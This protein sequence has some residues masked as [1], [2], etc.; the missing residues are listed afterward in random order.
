MIGL[1]L[2]IKKRLSKPAFLVAIALIIYFSLGLSTISTFITADEHFWLPNYGTERIQDYWRAIAKRD[3]VDTRINDKPGITLAYLSGLAIPFTQEA[4][5]KQITFTDGVIKIFDPAVTE[6]LSFAFRLPVFLFNGL[7]VAGYLFW[8]LKK[9]TRDEWVSAWTTSLMLLSPVL[10]GI[11]QIV[12]PDTLFWTFGS[13]TIFTFFAFLELRE[14]RFVWLTTLFFGLT[15]A[16]KYVGVILFPFF[17]IMILLHYLFRFEEHSKANQSFPER[18]KRDFSAYFTIIIGATVI[19]S[20]LMPAVFVKPKF[21]YESTIG[22]KGMPP[23]FL[24]LLAGILL[25]LW[26]AFRWQSKVLMNILKHLAPHTR[27]L[28]R[29][30]TSVLLATVVFALFNWLLRNSLYDLSDIPFDA[31]TKSSFT[32]DNPLLARWIVEFVPL[33][34]ALT[35][36]TLF[37][38]IYFWTHSLFASVK[39]RLLTFTLSLFFLIFY[40]AVIKQGLLVTIRYSIILFPFALLLGSFGIKAFFRSTDPKKTVALK[41]FASIMG[42]FVVSYTLTSFHQ[43]LPSLEGRK[44]ERYINAHLLWFQTFFITL[45]VILALLFNRLFRVRAIT[46]TRSATLSLAL[47]AVSLVSL[48]LIR[49]HYFIY[50]S[51]LLPKKYLLTGS[52]SYGGYEAAQYLNAKPNAKDL[53]LW[54]DAHG[55]CEFFVG[56]CI[57][58]TKLDVEQ[59]P[60]DYMFRSFSGQL[61]PKFPFNRERKPEWEY[62]LD[63]RPKNFI[64]LYKNNY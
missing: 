35:P 38:L 7:F 26:D 34:F 57:R 55:V 14:K 39:E 62:T 5:A 8:I 17:V 53:T 21:L 22:F 44:F 45:S 30:V 50:T 20:L 32:T 10:L 19:L 36:I 23:I 40:A 2:C 13:A 6:K 1:F 49:P 29:V 64:R 42:V 24:T 51:D 56:K 52:W 61:S 25:L 31:K 47:V 41:A 59:Y 43:T 63:G 28:E 48:I 3:W 16:S 18:V 27:T 15:L 12:N 4:I 33:V 46:K 60:V 54:S 11:S 9:I 58:K 37:T